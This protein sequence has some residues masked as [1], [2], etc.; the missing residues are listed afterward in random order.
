MPRFTGRFG[1]EG[2]PTPVPRFTTTLPSSPAARARAVAG[3]IS[4]DEA[5]LLIVIGSIC[6]FAALV[7]G[8]VAQASKPSFGR[9]PVPGRYVLSP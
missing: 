8:A 6:V 2:Q 3:T 5:G 9:S 1:F 4:P 7:L